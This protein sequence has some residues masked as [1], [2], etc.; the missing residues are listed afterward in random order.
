MQVEGKPARQQGEGDRQETG[1]R[2]VVLRAARPTGQRVGIYARGGCHLRAVFACAPMIRDVLRGTCGIYLDDLNARARADLELQT[3]RDLTPEMTEPVIRKL[4]LTDDY[5]LPRLFEENFTLDTSD[6]P[7]VFEKDV[8]IIHIGADSAGRIVYRHRDNGLLVDPGGGWL[9]SMEA[10]LG[11]LDSVRWFRQNFESVG[12]STVDDFMANFT[13][14]V[15][16]LRRRRSPRLL[17]FN[18]LLVEPGS[19]THTYQLVKNPMSLRWR[20]FHVAL[21]ELSRQLDFAVVDL[22]RV[23][24]LVGVRSQTEFAHFAPEVN[25][26]VGREIFRILER[27]GVFD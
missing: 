3:L 1:R 10:T 27:E 7:E 17:V 2:S 14:V 21:H 18:T 20:E 26:T 25:L 5:F 9:K 15:G 8:I 22:D 24:K 11:D 16:L 12:A 4:R 13:K 19:L 6:G 23:L